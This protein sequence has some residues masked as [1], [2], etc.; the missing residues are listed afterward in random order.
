MLNKFKVW[1]TIEI[2]EFE[3]IKEDVIVTSSHLVSILEVSW[4][5]YYEEKDSVSVWVV[6]KFAEMV[7]DLNFPIQI[8]TQSRPKDFSN[9][10]YKI[11]KDLKVNDFLV[12]I[13]N[14]SPEELRDKFREDLEKGRI[15]KGELYKYSSVYEY[16]K[17]LYKDE[18]KSWVISE[19]EID[20]L[21]HESNWIIEKSMLDSYIESLEKAIKNNKIYEKKYLIVITSLDEL[22][23]IDIEYIEKYDSIDFNKDYNFEKKLSIID[24]RVKKTMSLLN[25]K[26]WLW[27]IKYNTNDLKRILFDYYNFPISKDHI[28]NENYT[29]YGQLP[30]SLNN[31]VINHANLDDKNIFIRSVEW[32]FNKFDTINKSKGIISNK[33]KQD[34]KPALIDNSDSNFLQVNDSYVSTFNISWFLDTQ[35]KDL[36]LWP[37][38]S[39]SYVFDLS[40][41]VIPLDNDLILDDLKKMKNK[42]ISST[43]E[44]N[45]SAKSISEAERNVDKAKIEIQ[46]TSLMEKRLTSKETWIFSVSIDVTFRADSKEEILELNEEITKRFST[47]KINSNFTLDQLAGFKSTAPICINSTAGYKKLNKRNNY[48]LQ[49]FRHLFI[50]SPEIINYNSWLYS[51][52]SYQW[53]WR[54]KTSNV[55]FLDPFDRKKVSNSL[56]V[57]IW[58]SWSWK[59]TFKHH[60]YND[61]LLLGYNLSLLDFESNYY[62]WALDRPEKMKV[63]KIDS[64]SSDKI[65]PLDLYIPEN[66]KIERIDDFKWISD[67][68]IL[69]KIIKSKIDELNWYFKLFLDTKYD[70]EAKGIIYDILLNLYIKKTSKIN[71]RKE[72]HFWDLLFIDLVNELEKQWYSSL[73][74]S[75]R[76]Y[77]TWFF[78]SKTNIDLNDGKSIVFLLNGNKSNDNMILAT[79]QSLI[80]SKKMAYTKKNVILWIDEL[81]RLLWLWD[82]DIDK[83]IDALVAQ[84]RN[85]EW[86]VFWATQLLEQVM[87]SEAWEKFY[88]MADFKLYLSWWNSDGNHFEILFEKDKSLSQ[89]NK[90]YLLSS[91]KGHWILK[92][93]DTYHFKLDIHPSFTMFERY[94]SVK[95]NY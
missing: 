69:E 43:R 54:N 64:S 47:Y 91:W 21:Y 13:K 39:L 74:N 83:S 68:E 75:I 88:K 41:H 48:F 24:E 55:L 37:I 65:N 45:K 20:I 49:E 62:K 59:T 51:L 5:N 34:L 15:K 71:I 58:N 2:L 30:E 17:L 16:F 73:S 94:K 12:K 10:I 6:Q 50:F 32:I 90:N 1:D 95:S 9:H 57:I 14:E 33:I 18:L 53:E 60:L 76:P 80:L 38:L 78:D 87:K 31:S 40:I 8:I 46:D 81:A 4:I 28:Y 42:T 52:I 23:K 61:L 7:N 70:S 93:K 11:K 77:A 19:R 29:M 86:W 3:D 26:V 66:E 36:V 72:K 79:M 25:D 67:K 35:L 63:V 92:Y 22:K 89:S 27:A 85:Q 84:I 56:G 82:K 44:K